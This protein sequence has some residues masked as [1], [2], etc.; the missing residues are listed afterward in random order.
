ESLAQKASERIRSAFPGWTVSA[1]ALWGSPGK[2]ILETSEWCHPDLIVAGSHGRSRVARLFLGSVSQELIHKAGCS[3]RVAKAGVSTGREAIRLVIGC[4]SSKESDAV[5]R[6]VAGRSWPQK[7]E[8]QIISAFQSIT[9]VITDL[10]A[11]TYAHEHAYSVIREADE[12]M[13]MRLGNAT[14]ECTNS[15]LRAGIIATSAVVEG[16]PREVILAEAERLNADS[17]FVG[18]RGVGRMERLLLGSVSSYVVTHAHCTVE[19]V[20]SGYAQH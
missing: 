8:A 20:R 9:P 18:A 1:K 16:D 7:T 15:L 2:M 3:V 14:A 5:I 6:S 17:I 12:R 4:D 13:R 11:S 19:V 10:E